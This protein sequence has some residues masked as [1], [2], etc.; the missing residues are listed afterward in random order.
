MEKA[1]PLAVVRGD[2]L[3][4]SDVGSWESAWELAD[5]D[6]HGN[7]LPP[8]GIAIDAK[9]NFAQDL[10]TDAAPRVVALVGVSDLVVVQTDDALL[11]MDRSRAQ[12]VRSVVEALKK[13]GA[14]HV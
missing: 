4:W 3:A 13:R 11:V 12:D 5:K 2:G 14:G 7:A 10:R 8:R 6:E 1:E 9:G